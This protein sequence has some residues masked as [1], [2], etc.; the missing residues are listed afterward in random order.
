M[1]RSQSDR[2]N[3]YENPNRF[4]RVFAKDATGEAADIQE[5]NES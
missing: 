1:T 4:S 2:R 3:F 5:E